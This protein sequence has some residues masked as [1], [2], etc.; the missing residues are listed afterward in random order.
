MSDLV[1][2]FVD[3]HP[4]DGVAGESAISAISRWNTDIADQLTSGKRALSDSRGLPTGVDT[5]IHGGAIYRVVSNRQMQEILD[6]F[7]DVK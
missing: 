7:K 5:V 4:V 3:G 6:P 2:F 1:R